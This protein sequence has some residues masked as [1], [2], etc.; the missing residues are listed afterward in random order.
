MVDQVD[1]YD[2]DLE[3]AAECLLEWAAAAHPGRGVLSV[4]FGGGGLVLAHMIGRLRLDIPVVFLDTG[5]HFAETYSFRNGFSAKYGIRRI[6]VEPAAEVG[7]LYRTDPERCCQVRK[8]EPMARVL[9]QAD[10][11][12]T[13]LRRDQ[14]EQRQAVQVVEVV[15]VAGERSIRKLNPLADWTRADVAA[16]G[17]RHG[18]PRHPLAG[19]GYASI[20]C[21]PCTKPVP[22]GAPERAGRWVGREKTECGLHTAT[23]GGTGAPR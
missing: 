7:P 3:V 1:R 13:A 5:F 6:D 14:S 20:G 11:W 15:T 21:W 10:V 12:I 22:L 4:S 8:V 9:E 17:R 18:L 23:I 19:Q 2:P 16:Y